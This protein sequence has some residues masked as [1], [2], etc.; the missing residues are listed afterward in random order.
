[1]SGVSIV[2]PCYNQARFVAATV[3]SALA[4]REPPL[5]V[6]VV[7]DGSTD[8]VAG[9]LAAYAGRITLLRQA[10]RGLAG[11]RNSGLRAASGAYLLFLD[12]DDQ[13]EPEALGRLRAL[14]DAQP[15]CGL[16]YCAWRQIDASG[17]EVLGEV[18]PGAHVDPLRSLLLRRFFFFASGALIRRTCLEQVG[19][20]DEELPWG[21]D[22]DMW[23]RIAHAGYGFAYLDAVLLR[24]RVHAG[25]MTSAISPRQVASWGAG[26]DKFFQAPGL[27]PEICA[28]EYEA[29]AVL[30]FETA[31]R[32]YRAGQADAG[33]EQLATGL[34]LH[35]AVSGDWLLEWVAGTALDPRTGDPFGLI[36]RIGAHLEVE[37]GGEG[38]WR[39]RAYGRYHTA[40]C[41]AAAAGR[42]WARV[43]RHLA[44][45][46][47][48]DPALW[49]NR[50]FWRIAVRALFVRMQ[51]AECRN[52][53]EGAVIR[54]EGV[55]KA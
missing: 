1:M 14:L 35:P 19:A 30:H 4:Q 10:N 15:E 12:S 26:L 54:Q 34:R 24:Y 47:R 6:I 39:R 48:A 43:R 53:P 37:L 42:D 16:A 25:S 50:G 13:L 27:A 5:E 11:A 55:G 36:E 38:R 23:L 9:A 29:R 45:A 20:F 22:A 49:R 32:Y 51:N 52:V 44:P 8:D 41:F 2:I 31:G 7:D 18:H 46:L 33:R 3:A 40:A 28:L 21:E 17:T